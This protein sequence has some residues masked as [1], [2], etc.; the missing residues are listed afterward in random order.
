MLYKLVAAFRATSDDLDD[1]ACQEEDF[2]FGAQRGSCRVF[3]VLS[4][5]W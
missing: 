3:S 4:E 2:G 5:V 1:L